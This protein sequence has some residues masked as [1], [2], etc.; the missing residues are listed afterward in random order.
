M[1]YKFRTNSDTL[2]VSNFDTSK[3]TDMSSTFFLI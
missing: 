1:F 2:D 3:V